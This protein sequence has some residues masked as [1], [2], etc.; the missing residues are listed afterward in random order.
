MGR[1]M[2]GGGG[3]RKG[4]YTRKE[5]MKIKGEDTIKKELV[6]GRR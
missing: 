6:K 3:G 2:D 4:R 1:E 5:K